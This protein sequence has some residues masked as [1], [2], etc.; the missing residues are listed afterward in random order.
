MW[1]AP[2]HGIT[3]FHFR[4]CLYRHVEGIDVAVTPFLPVGSAAQLNVRR[5]RDVAPENNTVCETIPQLIGNNPPH[6]VDTI[7]E[8]QKLGYQRFNWNIGCPATQVVRKQRGC[9][10][11]PHPAWVEDVVKLVTE[12]TD[13]RFSVKMRLGLRSPGEGLEIVERL[14]KYPLDFLAVHP[15]LGVQQYEGV[16]DF[17]SFQKIYNLSANPLVYS[18]DIFDLPSYRHLM[19]RFPKVAAVMLGRGILRNPFLAEELRAGAPLPEEVRRQRFRAFYEDYVEM[20]R[21]VRGEQGS[22]SV[23]KELWHYF[24]HFFGLTE[25]VLHS[26]LRLTDYR[27]FCGRAA[28]IC[29]GNNGNE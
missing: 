23:L 29:S 13:C 28:E 27:E 15:R 25:P 5:W 24:A 12:E 17:D 21:Q 10:I 7:R 16:P 3:N 6:F 11:M 22:L 19:E 14:N 2:L 8:L 4:N 20:L 26:L 9:G 1:L 18:G